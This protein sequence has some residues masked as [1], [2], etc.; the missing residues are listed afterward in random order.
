MDLTPR[1]RTPWRSLFRC[2][3]P[4][5]SYIDI[6]NHETNKDEA[7]SSSFDSA[8]TDDAV[9]GGASDSTWTSQID[10]SWTS[11]PLHVIRETSDDD[12]DDDDAEAVPESSFD[13]TFAH[14]GT[15]LLE[16]AFWRFFLWMML[17]H[18]VGADRVPKSWRIR[19]RDND[20]GRELQETLVVG[21][22]AGKEEKKN[23]D[24]RR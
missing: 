11:T 3:D 5:S 4:S 13:S 9:A 19:E 7:S 15:I 22:V 12:D 2:C 24:E 14:P 23:N 20:D 6:D 10:K 16:M 1:R 17:R 21:D 18:V 8:G